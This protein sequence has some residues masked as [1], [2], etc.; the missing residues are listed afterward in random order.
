MAAA[1]KNPP[2]SATQPRHSDK[3]KQFI[4]IFLIR[5]PQKPSRPRIYGMKTPSTLILL[6]QH[7]CLCLVSRR[8]RG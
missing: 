5:L 6:R 2:S 3:N 1:G 7:A 4:A 8:L